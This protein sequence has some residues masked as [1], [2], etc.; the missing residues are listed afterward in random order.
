MIRQKQ[1]TTPWKPLQWAG[2]LSIITQKKGRQIEK[3]DINN[4]L[5]CVYLSNATGQLSH[6]D[7]LLELP[8]DA[9]ED[10]LALTGLKAVH[11]ATQTNAYSMLQ[12]V[13]IDRYKQILRIQID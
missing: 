4:K 13:D 10:N 6:L 3:E 8:L 2:Q 5:R 12:A 1:Y 7:L 9:G 11:Q